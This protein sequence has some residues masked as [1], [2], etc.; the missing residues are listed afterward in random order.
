MW[1][2][3]QEGG[4]HSIP[5]GWEQSS[6]VV[7]CGD[8]I[9]AKGICLGEAG[10]RGLAARAPLRALQVTPAAA[11]VALCCH[12]RGP[13]HDPGA[14]RGKQSAWGRAQRSVRSAL[15]KGKTRSG[16]GNTLLIHGTS[17]G[18]AK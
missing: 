4:V 3:M 6:G 16:Q 10:G 5:L 13:L 17:K 12:S 14:Y 7:A 2:G 11:Y 15:G 18:E 8:L 1:D 9:G